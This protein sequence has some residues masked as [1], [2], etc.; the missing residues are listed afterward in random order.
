VRAVKSKARRNQPSSS[1]QAVEAVLRNPATYALAEAIPAKETG[2]PRDYP[3]YMWIA[4]QALVSQWRS[5]P[6][7]HTELGDPRVWRFMRHVVRSVFPNDPS[8]WLPERPMRRH[9]YAYARRYLTDP[10]VLE[11]LHE[12]HS[13]EAISLAWSIGLLDVDRPGGF[14][15]PDSSRVLYGDGKV[16]TPL[17]KARPGDTRVDRATGEILAVRHDPDASLHFE[18]DGQEAYGT[19]FLTIATRSE[20]GRVIIDARHVGTG[21]GEEAAV[22]VEALERLAPVAPGVRGVIWDMAFRG[23]HIDRIMRTCGWLTITRVPAVKRR[24]TKGRKGGL[25]KEKERLIEVK[26][27]ATSDG[28]TT[29]V[30]IYAYAGT[31]CV[32]ELDDAGEARY[33]PLKRLRTQRFPGPNGYRFHNQ[34]QLPDS[35]G[36]GQVNLRLHSDDEDKAKRLNRAENL[37]AIA[38]GDPDFD[39]LYT[40]RN[41]AESINRHIEDTLWLGRAHSVGHLG[42]EADLLGFAL[43]VNSL[44]LA[45]HRAR[46]A[47]AA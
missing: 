33:I 11:R 43:L 46:E 16:I 28:S 23:V 39:G 37:R 3:T 17:F 18:G 24:R 34:Y 44:T 15:H 40:R 6:R 5:A 20:D 29:K 35:F 42:Q 12:V 21:D 8:M 25:R 13:T 14:T 9:H 27:V 26:D 32:V 2:R 7:V 22:A 38:P 47:V 10:E 4:Y 41:D 36:G 31:A 19:K 45:R 30:P 1:L